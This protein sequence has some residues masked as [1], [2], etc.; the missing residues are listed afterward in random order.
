M[1]GAIVIIPARYASVRFPG[2]VLADATGS[3]MIQHVWERAVKAPSVQR[4]LIATDDERVMEACDR[5]GAEAVMTSPEHANGTS[6]VAEA[7]L[8]LQADII[9]NVQGDEPEI[10][11][12]VIETVIQALAEDPKA[13]VSTAAAPIDRDEDP[14]DHNIV[15]VVR[16]L[17]G[18]ALYF[19][20]AAIPGSRPDHDGTVG[21]LK[22]LG[23]YGF[24]PEFLQQFVQMEPTPLEQH[25]QLEQLRVME[26]GH[27]ITVAVVQAAH[28]GIDTEAEY[29]SFVQRHG[30]SSQDSG[31]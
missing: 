10:S 15:K 27:R 25:E 8:G 28:A 20:R 18:R 6:R 9:V 29:E 13:S 14:D 5:F 1:A 21:H 12:G 4:V 3:P 24:R 22:H 26:H 23:L 16:D 30:Q 19:S 2:K 17:D 31:C 11:P 7:A